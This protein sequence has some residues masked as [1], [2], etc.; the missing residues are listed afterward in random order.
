M[1][2]G[3]RNLL[4]RTVCQ[5]ADCQTPGRLVILI[6]ITEGRQARREGGRQEEREGGREGDFNNRK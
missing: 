4:F 1:K 6:Q 2:A 3:T 5:T